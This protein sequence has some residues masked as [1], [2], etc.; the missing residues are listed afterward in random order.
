MA[1][2]DSLLN[3]SIKSAASAAVNDGSVTFS[4][5]L[6]LLSLAASGGVSASELSDLRSVYTN[7]ASSFS[8]NYLQSITYNVVYDNPG[9]A[10]WWGGASTLSGV[11]S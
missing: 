5:M 3:A 1:W 8:S 7:F 6:N 10:K 11:S 4:E 9:N 2:Y